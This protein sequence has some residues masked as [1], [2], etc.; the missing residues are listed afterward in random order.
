MPQPE[1]LPPVGHGHRKIQ[2]YALATKTALGLGG[3]GTLGGHM[4]SKVLKLNRSWLRLLAL[5]AITAPACLPE[6]PDGMP[7]EL[8]LRSGVAELALG[9]AEYGPAVWKPT[10]NYVNASRKVG[11]VNIVVVHTTQ[12]SFAGAVSWMQNPKAK[13]SAHYVISKKGEVVQMVKEEDIAWHVGS[14]N[15]YT[16]GIEHEGFVADANW[17]TPQLLDASAKLS[18]YLVKKWKLAPTKANIKGHVELPK[19]THT[20]PG[21][22]WPWDKYIGMVASCV[23]GTPPVCPNGCND[24][25]TCTNDVCTAGKCAHSNNTAACND[26]NACTSGDKCGGGKCTAG[27]AKNCNDNNACT[28]DG[29]DAKSGACTHSNTTATCN[30]S[31]ACTSGDK[32]G[33]GKCAGIAKV[34]NDKNACTDDSC[35]A[36]TGACKFANTSKACGDGG[37]CGAAGMCNSGQCVTGKSKDCND[38]NACTDDSCQST[39]GKCV[40]TNNTKPCDDGS[41]CS[42]GDQCNSGA[43]KAEVVKSCDDSNACTNDG[44][45]SGVCVNVPLAGPCNDGDGCTVG[46]SCATGFCT[47]IAQLCNDANP[48][49]ADACLGGQCVFASI[50]ANCDDGDACSENDTCVNNACSGNP[51]NCDDGK[52]CTQDSC[53]QGVCMHEG[54]VA[55]KVVCVGKDVHQADSC[56]VTKLAKTCPASSPCLAGACKS[57]GGADAGSS[58]DATSQSDTENADASSAP[59]AGSS[60][61]DD[62]VNAAGDTANAAG[63]TANAAGDTAN[64]QTDADAAKSDASKRAPNDGEAT[65][66]KDAGSTGG[67]DASGDN[68]LTRIGANGSPGEVPEPLQVPRD[69]AGWSCSTG[70]TSTVPWTAILAGLAAWIVHRQ[71]RRAE[72]P[73]ATRSGPV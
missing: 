8:E 51:L 45:K 3:L 70:P 15:G 18:C 63:D 49:T 12:G 33:A 29:C 22:Y 40:H 55:P 65:G 39:S 61:A 19:Q 52:T 46:D 9:A 57:V 24:N 13:V 23:N 26:G 54:G 28:T 34:C 69:Q 27:P 5:L 71:R 31:N 62:A 36:T 73:A 67:K 14:E 32:C 37:L 56:G 4:A 53:Q 68:G 1:S 30:D 72:T 48:C 42:T 47:G 6:S 2:W 59:D 16:I 43:C 17:V 11:N 7:N 35:T 50:A 60:A 21:K 64:A 20:D 10:V 25:N 58:A 44:C 38:N 41:A 66:G